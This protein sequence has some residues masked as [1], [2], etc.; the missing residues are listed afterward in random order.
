MWFVVASDHAY[1][2]K[3]VHTED[4]NAD[5]STEIAHY[6]WIFA[7]CLTSHVMNHCDKKCEG[8]FYNR[9]LSTKKTDAHESTEIAHYIWIFAKCLTSHVMNHCDKKC[10]GFFTTALQR[11]TL[12]S[13]WWST[14]VT[15]LLRKLVAP[16]VKNYSYRLQGCH[17][18]L[19]LSAGKVNGEMALN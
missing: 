8:F 18:Q 19:N 9:K 5:E 15:N 7:K 11:H 2:Q 12:W 17:H 4:K 13:H 14:R 16:T 1:T 3:I 10:E 6:V